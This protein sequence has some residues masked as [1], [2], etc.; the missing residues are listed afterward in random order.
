M[1]CVVS[2]A[3]VGYGAQQTGEFSCTLLQRDTL[4]DSAQDPNSTP[5]RHI[6]IA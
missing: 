6:A 4:S 3:G 2:G 1:F 5:A